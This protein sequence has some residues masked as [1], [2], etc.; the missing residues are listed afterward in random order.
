MQNTLEK[1][2][3]ILFL[4]NDPISLNKIKNIPIRMKL[5]IAIGIFSNINYII[6]ASYNTNIIEFIDN[7]IIITNQPYFV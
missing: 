1:I 3:T 7:S 6:S 5:N 4:Y 2:S